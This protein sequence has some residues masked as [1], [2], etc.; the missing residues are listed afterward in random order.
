MSRLR[1]AVGWIYI[2]FFATNCS[3]LHFQLPHV[4][5]PCRFLVILMFPC[6]A[7]SASSNRTWCHAS[8]QY[9]VY[10]ISVI[11]AWFRWHRTLARREKKELCRC[12]NPQQIAPGNVAMAR[13]LERNKYTKIM[14]WPQGPLICQ[15]RSKISS[16][17]PSLPCLSPT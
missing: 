15:I 2:E 14:A 4:S 1:V 16:F 5:F 3:Y 9:S 11:T 7:P 10:L 17:P 8:Q 6:H 13:R 12:E